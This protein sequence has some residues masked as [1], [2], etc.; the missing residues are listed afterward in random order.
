LKLLDYLNN[1]TA[2]PGSEPTP[3]AV[4]EITEAAAEMLDVVLP[5]IEALAGV[6]RH[7]EELGLGEEATDEI[8][9]VLVRRYV[10]QM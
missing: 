2:P 7:C 1:L 4:Q 10:E 5:G 8:M 6:R 9:R 3:T